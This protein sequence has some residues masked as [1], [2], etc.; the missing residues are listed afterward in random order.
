MN[1]PK[2]TLVSG[3]KWIATNPDKFGG[4]PIIRGTRFTI[5]FILGC[6]AEGMS[7]EEI[8]H[9]YS[10]FPKESLEEILLFASRVTDT[11]NVAA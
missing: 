9:D 2:D 1:E 4:K 7:Y 5:S 6:L 10:A 8:V 3:Y 11:P